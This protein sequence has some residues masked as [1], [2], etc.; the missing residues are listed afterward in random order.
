MLSE[1]ECVAVVQMKTSAP[2]DKVY[3][4]WFEQWMKV[5]YSDEAFLE[6]FLLYDPSNNPELMDMYYSANEEDKFFFAGIAEDE[7]GNMS[8]IYYGE[9]F[10]LSKSQCA[11]AEEFFQYVEGT[12]SSDYVIIGR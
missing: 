9:S 2:T 6:E 4:W 3:F 7:Y 5:E 12:R 10:T 11:P 8:P 1:C